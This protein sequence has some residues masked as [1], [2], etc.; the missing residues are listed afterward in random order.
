VTNPS[1]GT[2]ILGTDGK[3]I[4]EIKFDQKKGPG[5]CTGAQH[6]GA[7][8]GKFILINESTNDRLK[9]VAYKDDGTYSFEFCSQG[10]F[11]E[12][13]KELTYDELDEGTIYFANS[14]AVDSRNRIYVVDGSGYTRVQIFSPT[15]KYMHTFAVSMDVTKSIA[16]HPKTDEI[17]LA[18]DKGVKIFGA[19]ETALANVPESHV[20]LKYSLH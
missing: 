13:G 2:K 10:S 5:Q 19:Y 4:G 9:I 17:Y 15:G 18:Y 8:H 11:R 7:R 14:I 6:T 16:I 1:S 12:R 20:N 3:Q